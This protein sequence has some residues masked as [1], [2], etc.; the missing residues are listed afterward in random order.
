MNTTSTNAIAGNPGIVIPPEDTHEDLRQQNI[1][2]KEAKAQAQA[3]R[4][5]KE[6]PPQKAESK[7][8]KTE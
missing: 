7:G 5:N 4:E 6:N 8:S 2:A 3:E 1:K